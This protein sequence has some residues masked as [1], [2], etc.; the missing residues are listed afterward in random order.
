MLVGFLVDGMKEHGHMVA[1]S[2]GHVHLHHLTLHAQQGVSKAMY[3]IES[4]TMKGTAATTEVLCH[5]LTESLASLHAVTRLSTMLG[6]PA[7]TV[8]ELLAPSGYQPGRRRHHPP[9]CVPAYGQ[10][11]RGHRGIRSHQGAAL[12]GPA[13]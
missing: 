9:G 4:Q 1:L 12:P 10:G 8:A 11:P 7:D 5:R 3:Q 6:L 2:I 13:P